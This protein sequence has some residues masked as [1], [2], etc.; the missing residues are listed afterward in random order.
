VSAAFG[1]P[2]AHDQIGL[3]SGPPV[4]TPGQVPDAL[5]HVNLGSVQTN[6]GGTQAAT[7]SVWQLVA[8]S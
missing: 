5:V 3:G 6:D 8:L 1:V 4:A 2:S 7:T